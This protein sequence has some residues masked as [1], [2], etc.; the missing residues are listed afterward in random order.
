MPANGGPVVLNYAVPKDN[1]IHPR[2]GR[3]VAVWTGNTPSPQL[4]LVDTIR[5]VENGRAWSEVFCEAY[6]PQTFKSSGA[7]AKCCG[8][9]RAFQKGFHHKS[10]GRKA[11]Q[12]GGRINV[13]PRYIAIPSDTCVCM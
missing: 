5:T 13:S 4:V 10:E 8:V 12:V 1:A 6:D 7:E 11:V 9:Q 3:F 2:R